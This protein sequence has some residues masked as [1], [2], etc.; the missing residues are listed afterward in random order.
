MVAV[1][2]IPITPA[3]VAAA[4]AAKDL[5]PVV[6]GDL[7][8]RCRRELGISQ[9]ELA[10]RTGITP[11]TLHHY[12]SCALLPEP[13]RRYADSGTLAFKEARS[14]ADLNH[15]DP[16]FDDIA[17]IF[18]HGRLSSAYVESVSTKPRA[19]PKPRST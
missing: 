7:M 6:L 2:S 17:N 19:T 10:R 13:Y 18:V 5:S 14:L 11:G 16:R 12:E 1:A 4:Y 3:D 15:H 9:Q 8:L